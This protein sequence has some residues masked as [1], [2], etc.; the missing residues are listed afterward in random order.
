MTET[1]PTQV[2]DYFSQVDLPT[3]TLS[4]DEVRR[5]FAETF[6]V[7]IDVDALGSQQDQNFRVFRRGQVEPLGVLKLSNPVFS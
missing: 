2:F 7:E 5:L 4:D 1:A 6:G 3:P